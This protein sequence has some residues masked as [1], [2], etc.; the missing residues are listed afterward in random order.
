[1]NK[2]LT[3]LI[4]LII[5]LASVTF[6]VSSSTAPSIIAEDVATRINSPCGEGV[7]WTPECVSTPNTFG[8][9]STPVPPSTTIVQASGGSVTGIVGSYNLMILAGTL[10][11][12]VIVSSVNDNAVPVLNP[13]T[14]DVVVYNM[15]KGDK[16]TVD[17]TGEPAYRAKMSEGVEA[18]VQ[19]PNRIRF[20][21]YA[22]D[23][24][25]KIKAS[26]EPS[27]DFNNGL[28]EYENDVLLE[29]I[30]TTELDTAGVDAGYS[31]GFRCV[32]LA[33]NAS[34]Y[35]IVKGF[36]TD[37][38]SLTNTNSQSYDVCIKKT[39]YDDF[40]MSGHRFAFID[41][42]K[43]RLEFRARFRY[44]MEGL[45]VLESFDELN[46][47][48]VEFGITENKITIHNPTP[49]SSKISE[50]RS[51]YHLLAEKLMNNNV[52]RTHKFID[53]EYPDF[54]NLYSSDVGYKLPDI[55]IEDGMLVQQGKN[56]FTALVDN[57]V[58]CLNE[59]LNLFNYN[60][61]KDFYGRC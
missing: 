13:L 41:L 61:N 43:D 53:K 33:G 9:T 31:N 60:E 4:F 15:D 50:T 28:L 56:R 8:T 39:P 20:T 59:V 14:G 18:E 52:V 27:F 16:V 49:S 30:S 36:E 35:H 38:F 19:T 10:V 6:H 55:I 29:K 34:Y 32:T 3:L 44:L 2:E 40:S 51:G 48:F 7:A 47:I 54:I 26:E 46:H 58:N 17:Y 12:G 42:V 11:G 37:R 22:D 57:N 24:F 21:A 25:L 1:M 45:T 5:I 23:S